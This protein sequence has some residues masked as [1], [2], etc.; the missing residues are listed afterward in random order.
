[1]TKAERM[2]LRDRLFGKNP[3]CCWCGKV[4]ELQ[5]SNMTDLATLEHHCIEGEVVLSHQRC[6]R[7]S[8]S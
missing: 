8:F 4:M 7:D 1:V 2:S 5:P 6:N 3:F